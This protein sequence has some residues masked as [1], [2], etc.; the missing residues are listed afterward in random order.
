MNNEFLVFQQPLI[1]VTHV[2]QFVF[3][4]NFLKNVKK[5]FVV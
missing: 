2:T 1:R 3:L 5:I 4:I